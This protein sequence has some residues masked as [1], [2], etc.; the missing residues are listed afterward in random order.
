MAPRMVHDR[1]EDQR[2]CSTVD[3]ARAMVCPSHSHDARG[4]ITITCVQVVYGAQNLVMKPVH[5]GNNVTP[6]IAV[7]TSAAGC[8]PRDLADTGSS[9]TLRRRSL[10]AYV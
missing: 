2:E 4:Q 8:P 10:S 9:S 5:I 1:L 7:P 6:P 3:D